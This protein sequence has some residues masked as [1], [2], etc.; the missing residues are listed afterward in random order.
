LDIKDLV[1]WMELDGVVRNVTDFGAFVDI[2]L[3]SDWLV[4]K[5]QMADY[6][7]TNPI[8]VV[9]VGQKVKVKVIWIE[10]E[11]EKVSLSMKSWDSSKAQEI[12]LKKSDFKK[13]ESCD[14]SESVSSVFRSNI[15]FS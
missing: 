8:D 12:R 9:S 15:T 6:F 7:V 2:W 13:T 4:H 10:V 1:I 3:H 5:S 14:D 11:R